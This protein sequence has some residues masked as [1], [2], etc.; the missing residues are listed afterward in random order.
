M[1]LGFSGTF[2]LNNFLRETYSEQKLKL[3]KNIENFLNKKVDLGDYAGIR[4]MGISI[5]NSKINDKKNIDSEIKAKNVYV[6]IMPFRSLLNQKWVIKIK[7]EKTEI[8]INRDFFTREKSSYLSDKNIYN[9]NLNYDLNFYLANY[10]TLQLKEIGLNTKVK[11]GLIY[12]SADK[13][14]IANIKSTFEDRGKLRF[15]FNKKLN[16]DL[17]KF[18]FFT[19]GINL[20]LSEYKFGNREFFLKE[21]DFKSDLKFARR[22]NQ[23]IC[24]GGFSLNKIRLNTSGLKED[25]KSDSLNFDCGKDN[26]IANNLA[27]NYGNLISDL[28]L[29]I[30]LKQSAK[31]DLKGTIKF[32]ND[33]NPDLNLE[34][35]IPYS[36]DKRGVRFEKFNSKFLLN[37]TNL[38]HF[39]IF[40]E[41]GIGGFVTAKGTF[42]GNMNKPELLV[43]FIVVSPKYKNIEI[44]ET[45]EGDINNKNAEYTVNMNNRHTPVP[46][47]LTLKFDSNVELHKLN[48]SRLSRSNKGS[49]YGSLN[50][51]K[52]GD[53]FIWDAKNF[54]LNE[55]RLSLGNY[56][57]DLISGNINGKGSFSLRDSSYSGRLDWSLGE[58]RNIKF[59]NSEFSFYIKDKNYNLNSTLYPN[60]GGIIEI[61]NDSFTK[62]I[63]DISFE[64]V[65]TDWTLLTLVDILDIDNNQKLKN[66]NNNQKLKNSNNNQKL[67]NSNNNQKLKNSNNNQKRKNKQSE[68]LKTLNIDLSNKS[69][70]EKV[71]FIKNY[72][73]ANL[74]SGDKYN[75]KRLIKKFDGRYNAE[76]FLDTTE[77]NNWRIQDANLDGTVELNKN[78]SFVKKEKVSLRFDGGLMKGGNGELNVDKIPLK[79]LELLLDKPIDFNGSL[80]FDFVYNRKSNLFEIKDIYSINTSINENKFKLSNGNVK[81]KDGIFTPELELKYDNSENP[82]FLTGSIPWSNK[83][84][85]RDSGLILSGDKELIDIFDVLSGDY[86]NFKKG[87]F[88]YTF[89]IKGSI[90]KPKIIGRLNII[91]SEVDFLETSLRNINGLIFWNFYEKDSKIISDIKINEE[92]QAEDQGKGTLSIKGVLPL[93]LKDDD[94]DKKITIATKNLNLVSENFNYIYD[95]SLEMKGSFLKPIFSGV[96]TLKDGFYKLK[97]INLGN[98]KNI[99]DWEELN[100]NYDDQIE[101]N[102]IEII[103]DETPFR[104]FELKSIIPK[105]V[106]TFGF[107]NLK[108][109]LGPNFRLEY[110]NLIKAEL[111]TKP[112]GKDLIINGKIKEDFDKKE[113]DLKE[114]NDEKCRPI[115]LRGR[116]NLTNG[117][118]NYFTTPFKLNKNNDNHLAFASR[119]CVPLVD[120]SLISKVPQPIRKIYQSNK[121]NESPTDLSPNDNSRDFAAIGIGNTKLIR[122]EASYFG[123]LDELR[124]PNNIFL[125][126]TPSYSRSQINGLISINEANFLNRALISQLN[127][128]DALGG[129]F[130]FSL[131]QALIENN[132][133]LN[134][135]YS[136][137]NLDLEN[138]NESISNMEGYSEEWIAEIGFDITDTGWINFAVQTI[139]GRDDIPPQGVLT[140]KSD[141]FFNENIDL[142]VTGSSDAKGDWKS[143]LELFWRY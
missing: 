61:N 130:Q 71:N 32:K 95:S 87:D 39:N 129:R 46:S 131:Y 9:S 103:S 12:K 118:S 59:D 101:N 16:E 18:E 109:R 124:S 139:P 56:K 86:F 88:F 10:T 98:D 22:S 121:E 93:N 76:F 132:D 90:E 97:N 134:N 42:G 36:F 78:N 125:R 127:D 69:L 29:V 79:T 48:F 47:F 14:I 100:W 41:K 64:N 60:D 136:N 40:K 92:F 57:S 128:T 51:L 62:N 24:N 20:G 99:R 141:Q 65:S 1:S 50:M 89:N 120:F 15:K 4:F 30:P 114:A 45:W 67:K 116:I 119:S 85:K 105:Y 21:G 91:N 81:L 43:K 96:I 5:G 26:L 37:R 33:K 55:F 77:K 102:Q 23:I 58:Y 54:P 44:K 38:Q 17:T 112:P 11:G 72:N 126:S 28:A 138:S 75:L 7:P 25:I 82:T 143:Q 3:E 135:I 142:E 31:A 6:G 80:K 49:N 35:S 122:V 137:D 106:Q 63:Y 19:N 133:S 52:E 66:S 73:S 107:D 27:L 68:K 117:V 140:L 123:Y 94:T 104:L 83:S 34:G 115:S 13:E 84:E 113:Y 110:L 111:S 108:L 74:D 8:N 53:K 2:L 70:E